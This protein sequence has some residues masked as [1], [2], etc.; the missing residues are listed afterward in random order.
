MTGS[1]YP[2]IPTPTAD[3][4][5]MYQSM[6]LMQQ[7]LKLLT[8][9]IQKVTDQ[10]ITQSSQIFAKQSDFTGLANRVTNLEKKT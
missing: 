10:T 1:P 7:T 4:N 3:V 5:S 9:N 8:V 2:S 6:L